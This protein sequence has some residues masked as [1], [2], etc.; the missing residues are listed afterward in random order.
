MVQTAQEG[1]QQAQGRKVARLMLRCTLYFLSLCAVAPTS[2]IADCLT[3]I[4]IDLGCDVSNA[5]TLDERCV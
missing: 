1:Y 4:A 3:I 2:A 5:G